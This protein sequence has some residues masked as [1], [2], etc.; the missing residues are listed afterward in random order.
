MDLFKF[1]INRKVLRNSILGMSTEIGF[2]IILSLF[3]YGIC[4]ALF[5]LIK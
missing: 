2:I 5:T 1:K 4:L 3:L